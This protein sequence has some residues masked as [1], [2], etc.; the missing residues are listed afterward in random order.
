MTDRNAFSHCDDLCVILILGNEAVIVNLWYNSQWLTLNDCIHSGPFDDDTVVHYWNH[1]DIYCYINY[2]LTIFIVT[3]T[4]HWSIVI[5]WYRDDDSCFG[6][7]VSDL[8]LDDSS[9]SYIMYLH[10]YKLRCWYIAWCS[11]GYI[12]MTP[13]S[14]WYDDGR[15]FSFIILTF[16]SLWWWYGDHCCVLLTW[17]LLWPSLPCVCVF[18]GELKYLKE[19]QCL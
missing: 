10:W 1:I 15:V 4:I 5:H 2:L 14:Y 18:S 16:S 8:S 12:H 3:I 17:W 6:I 19:I 11:D 13:H 9:V 7:P